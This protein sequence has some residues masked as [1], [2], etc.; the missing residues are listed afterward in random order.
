MYE[1]LL[2]LSLASSEAV[3]TTGYCPTYPCVNRRAEHGV[4]KSGRRARR[5]SCAA[6]WTIYPAGRVLF[7]PGYGLC[8][9]E[10]TGRLVKGRHLDLY[11][12][13]T[14]EAEQWGVKYQF[15]KGVNM[16]SSSKELETLLEDQFTIGKWATENFGK[17]NV[18][19]VL[20][21]SCDELLEAMEVCVVQNEATRTMFKAMRL[22]LE[23]LDKYALLNEQINELLPMIAEELADSEIVNKHAAAV[24]S[25]DLNAYVQHKMTINRRRKWKTKADG[26]GQHVDEDIVL[27][28]I[29]QE[30]S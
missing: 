11:F 9:V 1:L 6:D 10:D 17:P 14:K 22:G 2:V 16:D 27:D 21:R 13:T 19:A 7:V 25:I 24:M 29:D 18:L 23:H 30:E 4:T 15:I 20:R 5:G 8:R 12:D 26:T 28:S 3:K